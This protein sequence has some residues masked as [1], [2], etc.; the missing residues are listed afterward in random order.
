MEFQQEIRGFLMSR[1]AR[2]TPEQAGLPFVGG[3]RRVEGLR[4]EEVAMLAG[5]SVE[6]YTRL[7]R[8]RLGGASESVLDAIARTLQLDDDERAHLYDLARNVAP[9]APRRRPRPTSPITASVQQVLDSMSV[10]AV[11]QNGRL[12]LLAANDLG[13]ALYA[14]LFPAGKQP[15]NFAR[16]VFLDPRAEAFYDDID[17]AKNLLV[18]ILRA[19]AG[20]DPLDK[21]VS[22]LIGE[23]SVRSTDFGT[24]W[25]KHNV[26]RHSR[27]RKVVHHR[28]VGTLELVY[29]DF[30]LPG[31]PHVTITTW[32]AAPGTPSADGL[33]LLATWAETQKQAQK[34]AQAM[35]AVYESS[36]TS[37]ADTSEHRDGDGR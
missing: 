18:A 28:A 13:R 12:D 3:N 34:Q 1:R 9:G 36:T 14:D 7:E 10:P 29:D 25:A 5:L 2:I 27:G 30:A 4:R 11:V 26:R 37:R 19:T 20:R 17:Q 16:Y 33:T 15:P 22:E 6:Y 24:R 8:G 31:D 23:L 35:D 21:Q 32:T